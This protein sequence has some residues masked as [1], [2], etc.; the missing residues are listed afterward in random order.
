MTRQ[1]PEQGPLAREGT[2]KILKHSRILEF[3][4]FLDFFE[5]MFTH[6]VW[7]KTTHFQ[8]LEFLKL[9]VFLEFGEDLGSWA[10]AFGVLGKGPK[11][12]AKG[13]WGS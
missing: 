6:S 9:L 4:E 2:K 7:G 10:R 3:L 11:V 13:L 12:L 5:L 1:G 8:F